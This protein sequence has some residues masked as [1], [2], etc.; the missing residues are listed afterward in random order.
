MDRGPF[1][2][3]E[4]LRLGLVDGLVWPDEVP[5]QVTK[6]LGQPVSMER[7]PSGPAHATRWG[8][9]PC[10][11]ILA[12]DGD[13]VDGK[14]THIPLIDRRTAGARTLVATLEARLA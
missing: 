5:A 12:V 13:I 10:V 1:T 6:L 4:A 8:R 14:S 11:A 7:L 3:A 9:R 2:A